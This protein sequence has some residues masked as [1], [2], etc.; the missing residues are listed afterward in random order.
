MRAT[1]P[2]I[3]LLLASAPVW[4]QGGR[5]AYGAGGA[6]LDLSRV[7][8]IE[9]A[10]TAVRI[11]YGAQYPTIDV[12]GRSV[13][14]APPWFLLENDF[15]LKTGDNVQV[16]AAPALARNAGLHAIEIRNVASGVSIALRDASGLPLWTATGPQEN[17]APSP[18]SGCNGSCLVAGSVQTL[19]GTIDKLT[20]GPGIEQPSLMLET[21]DGRSFDIRIGPE[22]ILLRSNFELK[23]GETVTVK[24]ALA[25][26]ANHCVALEI[27]NSAGATLVLRNPDGTP[28]W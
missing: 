21:P 23:V 26:A 8:T 18:R 28:A 20:F 13:T 16:K 5:G 19:T 3:F 25:I 14:V 22:R 27:T 12:A 15:E 9:G 11:A 17:R 10:V 6:G 2:V 24:F 4:A 7:E 1:F